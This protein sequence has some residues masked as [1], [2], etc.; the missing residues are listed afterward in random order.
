[1]TLQE[2]TPYELQLAGVE[3]P[4][5]S[6]QRRNRT[7][8]QITGQTADQTTPTLADDVAEFAAQ[9]RRLFAEHATPITSTDDPRVAQLVTPNMTLARIAEYIAEGADMQRELGEL[10]FSRHV[11]LPPVPA[12]IIPAWGTVHSVRMPNWPEVEV[13][14]E[15]TPFS[16]DNV[17][18]TIETLTT[19]ALEDS[20]SPDGA[21]LPAGV[22]ADRNPVLVATF[23]D[24]ATCE[25]PVMTSLADL[26]SLG[27]LLID[28]ARTLGEVTP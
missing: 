27:E 17:T 10:W 5:Q 21:L 28:V 7:M 8:S 3:I 22:Y 18:L 16:R 6:D 1:M 26:S 20:A 12:S 15:S 4:N 24:V 2:E 25:V 13:S 9:V 23:G 19:V 14:I 11:T